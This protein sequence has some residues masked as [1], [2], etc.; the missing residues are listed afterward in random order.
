MAVHK[1]HRMG[2]FE[3]RVNR[4]KLLVHNSRY[5]IGCSPLCSSGIPMA[6]VIVTYKID[7][8]AKLVINYFH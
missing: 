5:D 2:L 6:G 3:E 4:C 1:K 7:F 8:R